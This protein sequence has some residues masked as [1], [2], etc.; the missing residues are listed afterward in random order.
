[1]ISIPESL[2]SF[3]TS[4]GLRSCTVPSFMDEKRRPPWRRSVSRQLHV[5]ERC[6]NWAPQFVPVAGR[7]LDGCEDSSQRASGARP[8]GFMERQQ[9]YVLRSVEER[10]IRF[11]RLWF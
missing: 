8:G 9:D 6:V 4:A 3:R 2:T 7:V 10:G 5:H 11:I 1:M